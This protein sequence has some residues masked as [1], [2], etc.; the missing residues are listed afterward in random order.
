[1]GDVT[2]ETIWN[3]LL[4][5]EWVLVARSDA[6]FRR[7]LL[8]RRSTDEER[9]SRAFTPLEREVVTATRHACSL[10]VIAEDLGL[11]TSRV[12]EVLGR[13]RAK[14]GAST[15]A[16]LVRMIGSFGLPAVEAKPVVAPAPRPSGFRPVS[17]KFL[18]A[19]IVTAASG[20]L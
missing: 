15:R 9:A 4:A 6:T 5:G 11:S 1:M 2:G 10:K 3:E 8:L 18:P 7:T 12:A 14:L 13:V 16:D 20:R 17:E 19:R